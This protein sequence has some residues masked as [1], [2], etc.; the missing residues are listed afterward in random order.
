LPGAIQGLSLALE[1]WHHVVTLHASSAV[2]VSRLLPVP[3]I[4][5]VRRAD[6]IV[7]VLPDH[8]PG[9]ERAMARKFARYLHAHRGEVS[10]NFRPLKNKGFPLLR[11]VSE[12]TTLT[13]R[14]AK[15]ADRRSPFRN[16]RRQSSP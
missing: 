10:G 5:L 8:L 12:V 7:A 2:E 4:R 9:A 16:F 6:V 11:S 13:G 14:L 15:S 1:Y 3:G